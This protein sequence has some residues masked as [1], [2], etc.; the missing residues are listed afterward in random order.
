MVPLSHRTCQKRDMLKSSGNI[1]EVTSPKVALLGHAAM[2]DLGPLCAQERDM[3]AD[4][5][6]VIAG[7]A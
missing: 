7:S 5:E 4:Q 2:S 3:E 6:S 1:A